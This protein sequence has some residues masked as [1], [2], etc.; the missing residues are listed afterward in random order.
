MRRRPRTSTLFPY[1]TLFRSQKDVGPRDQRGSDGRSRQADTA[2]GRSRTHLPPVGRQPGNFVAGFETGLRQHF[3]EH[4]DALSAK[5]GHLDAQI[6]R[7]VGRRFDDFLAGSVLEAEDA[8]NVFHG[9]RRRGPGPGLRFFGAVAQVDHGE[10]FGHFVAHEPLGLHRLEFPDGGAG[11]QHFHEGEAQALDLV[12]HGAAQHFGGAHDLLVVAQRNAF[13]EDR[14][15]QRIQQFADVYGVAVGVRVAAE[16]G[17]G[18]LLAKRRSGGHLAAG[19]AV[20]TVVDEDYGDGLAA[21]GGVNDLRGADGRQI[22]IALVAD[23]DGIRAAALHSRR[24]GGR[25]SVRHL[26]VADVEIVI[27]K[28]RAA[29]RADQHGAVLYSQIVE[30]LGQQLV[31]DAVPATGAVVRLVLQ[32]GFAFEAVVERRGLLVGHG[33]ASHGPKP[34]RDGSRIRIYAPPPPALPR[35]TECCRRRG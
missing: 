5:P 16:W 28:Y 23:Y 32:L 29:H 6:Q 9:R 3:A 14:G 25:A 26:D 1:T 22:A 8:R 33:K 24:H 13:D 2:V 27:S 19:H 20:D 34:P 7:A 31:H 18:G 11:R 15:L 30:R 21:V 17:G 4:Q 10:Y 35:R 12:L